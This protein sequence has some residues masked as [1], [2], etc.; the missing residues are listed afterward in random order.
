MFPSIF[1]QFPSSISSI[2]FVDFLSIFFQFSFFKFLSSISLAVSFVD[3]LCDCEF[4]RLLS[5]CQS[6][7]FSFFLQFSS[8]SN[9]TSDT[10]F[11]CSALSVYNSLSGTSLLKDDNLLQEMLIQTRLFL[12]KSQQSI[13]SPTDLFLLFND[14]MVT[15]VIQTTLIFIPFGLSQSKTIH[16]KTITN[17]NITTNQIICLLQLPIKGCHV[18]CV[19]FL[20]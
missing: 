3:R 13:F 12:H 8:K 9:P 16:F 4:L 14:F 2:F 17:S 19:L 6:S 10:K 11:F 5:G 20:W 1:R 15:P 7:F 18:I